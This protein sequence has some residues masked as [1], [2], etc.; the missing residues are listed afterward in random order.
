MSVKSRNNVHIMGSGPCTIVFVHGLGC[1]QSMWRYLAPTFADRFRVVTLDLVGSGRSDLFAYDRDKYNTLQGYADDLLEIIDATANGPAVV[2]G[3]SV[4]AM[5]GL[6]ATI[7]EPQRFAAQVMVGP[8]PCYINDDHYVGGFN[9]EDMEMLL[10]T[11]EENFLGW[12]SNLV[13]KI[14]GSSHYP[15]LGEQLTYK[16]IRN[17]PGIVKHFARVTFLSD[18]RA[19]LPRSTV[20]ALILQCSD[21]LIVPSEVSHYM[22]R[23]LQHSVLRVINSDSHCPHLT[24]PMASSALMEGFLARILNNRC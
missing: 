7:K 1:D 14:V 23:H 13:P 15:A 16:F 8:S 22:H 12:V 3:H 17:A 10:E 21:D 4:G 11:M 20:P 18:H 2:V 5:I 9:R 19:D 6:L 24:A